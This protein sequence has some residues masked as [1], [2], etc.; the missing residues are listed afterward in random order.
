M[1]A[2]G[3]SAGWYYSEPFVTR[4]S[5]Q[6]LSLLHAPSRARA[7]GPPLSSP[8]A[9]FVSFYGRGSWQY[10]DKGTGGGTRQPTSGRLEDR[11]RGCED[12]SFFLPPL[13]LPIPFLSLRGLS[14]HLIRTTA[15]SF[16]GG[17]RGEGEGGSGGG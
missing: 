12:P 7:R 14:I 15:R 13:P 3:R 6:P 11:L 4:P 17:G 1:L 9:T 8:P 16:A 2:A 5:R 10:A